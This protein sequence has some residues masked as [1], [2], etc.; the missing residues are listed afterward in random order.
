M[1][2]SPLISLSK[3]VGPIF[4]KNAAPNPL[5]QGEAEG[6]GTILTADFLN[7]VFAYPPEST[8]F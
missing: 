7:L 2:T 5:L 1:L 6:K 8:Y 4:S 3:P